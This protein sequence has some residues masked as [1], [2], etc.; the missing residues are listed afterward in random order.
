[1]KH[2]YLDKPQYDTVVDIF[3]IKLWSIIYMVELMEY[4]LLSILTQ[5]HGFIG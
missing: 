3:L 4:Y 1:M 2:G 5:R